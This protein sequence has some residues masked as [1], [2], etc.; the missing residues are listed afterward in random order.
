M[1]GSDLTETLPGAGWKVKALSEQEVPQNRAAV[2]VKSF[3]GN[4]G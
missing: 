1:V 4:Q 2:L 3:S